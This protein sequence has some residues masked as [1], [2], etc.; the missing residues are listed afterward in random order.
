MNYII[1]GAAI[2][3][4][5]FLSEIVRNHGPFAAGTVFGCVLTFFLTLAMLKMFYTKT[6]DSEWQTLVAELRSE[7]KS[8]NARVRSLENE[9]RK[10]RKEPKR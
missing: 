1:L 9:L 4:G 3:W 10:N 2:D 8:L 6:P 7:K 5:Q